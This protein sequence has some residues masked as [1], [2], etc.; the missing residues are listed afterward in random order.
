MGTGRIAVVTGA[1]GGIGRAI[2]QRLLQ[3]QMI[4][5]A[6]DSDANA[7][8]MLRDQARAETLE[9]VVA[10]VTQTEDVDRIFAR[11]RQRGALHIL[12]NGV[13]SNCSGGLRDLSLAE[14]Q[15]KFDLNL[16]SV[17]LCTAAA[18]PLLEATSGDRVVINLSSTLATVADPQ[19]L[20]YSAFKAGLEQLTR[21][22]ALELAP[23]GI[24]VVTVAPGPVSATSGEA[25]FDSAE[26]AALNPLGRFATPDEVATLIEFIASPAAAY[27]TGTTVRLDGGDS[28]LGAGWGPLRAFVEAARS[29]ET[30]LPSTGEQ[31]LPH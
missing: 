17:F 23:S 2:A 24:R 20:A 5:V 31:C 7:L 21:G 12:V 3:Q 16:T 30:T 4:V 10:D 11:V 25:S 6:A 18:L 8:A 27:L 13:G 15:R 1:G 19:T 14:W 26:W 9:T 29:N 22:L 28:A